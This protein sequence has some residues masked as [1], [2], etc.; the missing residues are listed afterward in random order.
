VVELN[1]QG[2]K[3]DVVRFE[4]D[5]TQVKEVVAQSNSAN[6]AV[7]VSQFNHTWGQSSVIARVEGLNGNQET[8]I[9]G[10]H[11]D[12]INQQD[13]MNGRAPG[14]DD[15]GSGVVTI[16][17]TLRVLLVSGYQPLRPLE[18]HFY[19]AEEVGLLGSQAIAQQYQDSNRVVAGMFQLDMTGYPNPGHPDIGILTDNV[20]ASLTNLLRGLVTSYST[21]ISSDFECGYGCS[22]HASWNDAGY[23]V[24][25]PFEMSQMPD[26]TRIHTPNDKIETVDYDHA[27]QFVYLALGFAVE[28]SHQ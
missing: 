28:M 1:L 21:L 4:M 18:F 11:Q 9:L 12:S 24:A 10:A 13:R 27:L 23:P 2:A 22:D 19:S 7:T 16:L 26:F 5:A 15:D 8:V 17:E 3:T 25:L 6:L 14:A 20:D